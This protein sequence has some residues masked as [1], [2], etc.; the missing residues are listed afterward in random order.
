[1]RKG[2]KIKNLFDNEISLLILVV[3]FLINR[4]WLKDDR[5]T[6]QILKMCKKQFKPYLH[7]CSI[8]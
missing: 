8:K 2:V 5:S 6:F 7:N 3:T 4:W 1:M